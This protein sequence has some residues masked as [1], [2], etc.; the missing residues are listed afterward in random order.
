VHT[1]FNILKSLTAIGRGE[2]RNSQL[3]DYPGIHSELL[4]GQF[5][6][7]LSFY[8]LLIFPIDYLMGQQ[9]NC[10]KIVATAF[11]KC[12]SFCLFALSCF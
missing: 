6:S 7:P 9:N 10:E 8:Y 12:G 3:P 4:D 2:E 1:H 5:Y 11:L